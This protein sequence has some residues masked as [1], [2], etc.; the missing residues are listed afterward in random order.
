MKHLTQIWFRA[1]SLG[2]TYCGGPIAGATCKTLRS[3]VLYCERKH[4]MMR[5]RRAL[6]I[7]DGKVYVPTWDHYEVEPDPERRC[8]E[9]TMYR[10][11]D[12]EPVFGA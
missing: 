7:H 1:D 11:A 10:V 12:G 6:I 5:T 2:G 9:E 3:A 4:R 8:A